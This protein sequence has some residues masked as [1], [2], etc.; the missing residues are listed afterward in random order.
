MITKEKFEK[1]QFET[2]GFIEPEYEKGSYRLPAGF[3]LSGQSTREIRA[4]I[5]NIVHEKKEETGK[6]IPILIEVDCDISMATYKQYISGKRH[7][8]R[9]FISKLCVGLKLS[10]EKANELLRAHSG[11][12]NMTND[13]DAVTFFAL[14]SKDDIFDYEKELQE[15]CRI[16]F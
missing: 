7:P 2:F 5:S 11:E 15:K 9:A 13:A 6:T 8:S 16:V 4:M 14:K 12:L 3:Q 1:M 10:I